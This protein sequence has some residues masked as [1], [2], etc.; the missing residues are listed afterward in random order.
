[1]LYQKLFQITIVLFLIVVSLAAAAIVI[2]AF[3]NA[4]F[5]SPMLARH[6]DIVF[7]VGGLSENR[8]AYMIV[9]ASLLIAGFYLFFRRSRFRR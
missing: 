2:T 8:L 5:S 1:M 9:A 4:F 3:M 7:T 6:T